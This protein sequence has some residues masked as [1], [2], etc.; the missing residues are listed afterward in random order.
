MPTPNRTIRT[1]DEVWEKLDAIAKANNRTRSQQII[2][3]IET[4]EIEKK[5]G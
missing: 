5:N 3:W 2:H 1:S 4:E